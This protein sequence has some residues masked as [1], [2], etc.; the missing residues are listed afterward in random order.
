MEQNRGKLEQCYLII[1]KQVLSKIRTSID[2]VVVLFAT[3]FAFNVHY[4]VGCTNVYTVLEAIL[5][6]KTHVGRR[7]RVSAYLSQLI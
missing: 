3:F 4:P 2:A 7:P 6:E 5:L 1:E